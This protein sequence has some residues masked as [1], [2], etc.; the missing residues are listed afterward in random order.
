MW[1]HALL[2][3]TG[4]PCCSLPSAALLLCC[5]A[6]LLLCCSAA[7]LLC[8]SAALLAAWRALVAPLPT[9]PSCLLQVLAALGAG[10]WF[11]GGADIYGQGG[12]QG[13]LLLVAQEAVEVLHIHIDDL[14]QHGGLELVR[15]VCVCG[16][17][18]GGS[19][20]QHLQHCSSCT[21][22]ML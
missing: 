14:V 13:S 12:V 20:V 1:V 18:A 10:H 15:C 9:R 2:C 17:G 6:A 4:H 8:C 3:Q 11:G 19:R 21:A 16:G 5:S 22:L 7:L